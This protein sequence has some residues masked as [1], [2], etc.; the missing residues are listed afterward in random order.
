MYLMGIDVGTTG[1]KTI[2]ITA[3][4]KLVA[5]ANNSYTVQSPRTNWFEQ[6]PV[7]WWNGTVLSIKQMLKESGIDR[8]QISSIGLSGMYHGSVLLGKDHKVLRPC[9]LWND[10]RTEKQSDYIIGKA[11]SEKL[12]EI[13]ATPGGA[14]FTACKLLWVRDNEPEIYEKLYKLMLPKDYVRFRLTGEFATD[15]SDASGTLF[16]NIKQRKWSKE[17]TAL[18]DVDPSILPDVYE[19]QEISGTVSKIAAEATGLRPGIPVAGGAGDQACAALGIGV[20]EEGIVSYSIGT[21]GVIYATSGEVRKDPDG[22][23]NTFCHS[24]PGQWCQLSCIN[25]AAGSFQWFA[26]NFADLER[27][28]SEKK[29]ISVYEILEEKASSVPAGSDKLFFL[30]YLAGERHPH[31]DANAR[32]V[33][34]GYHMGH[35]KAHAVRAVLEGVAYSFRDCL[36]VIKGLGTDIREIRATGGGAQSRLWLN[37]MAN[38]SGE[39]IVTMEAEQGGAAFGAAI[40]GSI[41]AKFFDNLKEACTKLVKTRA[42]LEPDKKEKS[43]YDNYFR[44]FRSLYPLLKDSYKKLSDL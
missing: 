12:M 38:V 44:F 4:G 11:G 29:G 26:D 31:T 34:F 13:A 22:R 36:D 19:S 24:V 2:L 35:T 1:V 41:G 27:L 21:S 5:E 3:E 17:M 32:G 28:E 40:L 39:P 33:F 30:P 18:L 43:L 10:Q 42:P 25:A 7:D 6:D 14:Y 9:I 37:I 16:L 15:V 8:S 20:V 23:T